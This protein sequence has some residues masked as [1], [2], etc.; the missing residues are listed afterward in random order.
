VHRNIELF[1]PGASFL[2]IMNT[3]LLL[4][5]EYQE[6]MFSSLSHGLGLENEWPI[7]RSV[8]KAETRGGYGGGYDGEILAGMVIS[9]ESYIGE[10]GGPDGVKLEEQILN[11]ENGPEKL[12]STPYELD[13]L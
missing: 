4:P 5:R 12:S 8:H 3:N 13:W 11:T 2:E 7:I 9:I 6:Q 10:V 1:Q